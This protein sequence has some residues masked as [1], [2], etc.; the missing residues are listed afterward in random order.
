M[1]IEYVVPGFVEHR[2]LEDLVD[3]TGLP[4]EEVQQNLRGYLE[5]T[6]ELTLMELRTNLREQE[7]FTAY[8][9]AERAKQTKTTASVGVPAVALTQ[10]F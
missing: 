7:E 5:A 2:T 10:G 3:A 6:V 8:V 9:M 4:W 1:R